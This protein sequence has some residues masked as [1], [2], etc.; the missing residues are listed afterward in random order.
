M[1]LG[2]Y[3]GQSA[4]AIGVS[5]LSDNGRAVFKANLSADTQSQVAVGVGMGYHF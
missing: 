5:T 1:G 2:T 3:R 4:V